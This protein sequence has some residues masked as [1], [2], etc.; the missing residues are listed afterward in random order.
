MFS[1]VPGIDSL[2]DKEFSA[3]WNA[4]VQ[5]HAEYGDF[6]LDIFKKAVLAKKIIAKNES[7]EQEK[8]EM[9][10]R[11]KCGQTATEFFRQVT[12]IREFTEEDFPS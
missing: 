5:A 12:R 8:L 2:D 10:L 1:S 11:K 3:S 9:G 4:M 6:Y 7:D